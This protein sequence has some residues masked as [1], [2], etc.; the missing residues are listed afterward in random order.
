MII[1]KKVLDSIRKYQ[2]QKFQRFFFS[3]YR[4]KKKMERE[5]KNNNTATKE[6]YK[7]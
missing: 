2:A 1:I 3:L 4:K 5:K 7:V 6:S